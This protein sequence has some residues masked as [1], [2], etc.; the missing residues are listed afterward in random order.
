MRA[1]TWSSLVVAPA[2]APGVKLAG[3]EEAGVGVEEQAGVERPV[4]KRQHDVVAE[5]VHPLVGC[6]PVLRRRDEVTGR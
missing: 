5:R 1:I 2:L 6:E 4:H 3:A